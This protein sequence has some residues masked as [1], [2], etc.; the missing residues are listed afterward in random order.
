MRR[1]ARGTRLMLLGIGLILPILTLVPLG[2]VWLWQQGYAVHWA[3]GA[4]LFT[5]FVYGLQRWLLRAPAPKGTAQAEPAAPRRPGEAAP[6]P[7]W[8]PAEM[9]AWE[10]VTAIAEATKPEELTSRE[11]FMSL[12][13]STIEAVARE[14][15]PGQK[16]PLW[17][18]TVPEA[19]G[20]IAQ[21]SGRLRLGVVD[22]VPLGD[23]LTVGQALK[24]YRWRSAIDVAEHAY[25][26]WR[27]VRM[28]NP[29]AAATQ[30]LRE[31]VTRRMYEWGRDELGARLARKFVFEVGRGAMDL[32][33]GRLRISAEA[34]AAH[35]TERSQRD[36]DSAGKAMAEPLRILIA[37]Q[38]NAGKSSLINALS[39]EI[40]AVVDVLPAT[41][42]VTPHAIHREG[43]PPTLLLDTQG[44][45][46]NASNLAELVPEAGASDFV[47]WVAN[48]SRADRAP[49][50]RALAA[51][52]AA[53][54]A[55][56]DRRAPPMLLVLTHVDRLRPFSEWAP[57][58]DLQAATLS[59]KAASI[60]AA[61]EAATGELGFPADAAVPVCL[62][63]EAGL[64]NVDAVWAGIMTRLPDAKRAQLVRCL[65]EHRGR[66]D[67]G[68]LWSQTL[69]AGRVLT[70]L[71]RR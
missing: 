3:A 59:P 49:D 19:L 65:G 22:A 16:D 20:L 61:V 34:L 43:Q 6:D 23:R 1:M 40:K 29:M 62:G 57:P 58:Y 63:A 21:V 4:C 54:A 5:L 42:T 10:R 44:L 27:L 60:K 35:V 15:H 64:Y 41:P 32:Y 24:L 45:A 13:Q 12:A 68:K 7:G 28:V 8:T 17:Q 14:I 46:P 55:R 36:S 2:G 67:W 11:A 30:E 70:S 33:G 31:Q 69:N 18:F 9:R 37:G 71:A 48:A 51:L 38:V 56:P 47:I 26:L 25:D 66:L 52:R 50:A 53:F 39:A